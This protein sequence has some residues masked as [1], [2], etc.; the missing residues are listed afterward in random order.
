MMLG[1][2]VAEKK[3]GQTDTQTD[4]Q[5][6]CFI[7]IDYSNQKYFQ[8]RPNTNAIWHEK[9]GGIE[10]YLLLSTIKWKFDFTLRPPNYELSEGNIR[11]FFV[12]MLVNGPNLT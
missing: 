9:M 3:C 1:L 10:T 8:F 6:S 4:T 2:L 5:D 11:V 7:S 12:K